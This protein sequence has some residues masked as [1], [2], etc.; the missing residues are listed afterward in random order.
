MAEISVIV[1]VYNMEKY[2]KKCIESILKQSFQDI[3]VILVDDGSTDASGKIC[4]DYANRDSRIIVMH[5][6]NGG[7]ADARNH[8]IQI[9]SS[10]YITYIDSD[11]YVDS[12]YLEILYQIIQTYRA[13]LAI[14]HNINVREEKNIEIEKFD[15]DN[16]IANTEVIS[17]AETYRRMLLNQKAAF[18]AWGKLYHRRLFQFVRYPKGELYEDL[19]VIDQIIELSRKIVYI[20]YAGYFYLI[21]QGSI[22]HGEITAEHMTSVANA[23]DLLKLI[24]EKYP[25]IEKSAKMYYAKS[26][27][28]MLSALTGKP[29]YEKKCQW[30][31]KEILREGREYFWSE[32]TDLGMKCSLICLRI[33][34]FFYKNVRKFYYMSVNR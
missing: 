2:L 11:D 14:C 13:D 24:R 33:G 16:I 34:Y 19:K 21:R 22:V 4:D 17:K 31:R 27:Y 18:T 23:W 10:E 26:C 6:E 5:K 30:L 15:Y 32:Y 1:P 25:G 3:E 12:R 9:S 20:P 8:G 28:M 7:P 29:G